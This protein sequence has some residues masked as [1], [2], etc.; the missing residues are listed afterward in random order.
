[1]LPC[2]KTIKCTLLA[3]IGFPLPSHL[4]DFP[5]ETQK[6]KINNELPRSL[7]LELIHLIIF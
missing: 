1:M 5:N 6:T 4:C 2:S 3:L 7:T